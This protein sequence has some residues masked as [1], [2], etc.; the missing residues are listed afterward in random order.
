[1]VHEHAILTK[2]EYAETDGE[3]NSLRRDVTSS[4]D[5]RIGWNGRL[6]C[7]L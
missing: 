5:G 4:G 1:M 2:N 6:F 3:M 7:S